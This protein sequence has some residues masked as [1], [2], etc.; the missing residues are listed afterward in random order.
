M[1]YLRKRCDPTSTLR[2][3]PFHK[4]RPQQ[5]QQQLQPSRTGAH[6]AHTAVAHA[7]KDRENYIMLRNFKP[8]Y[9]AK[10]MLANPMQ[11]ATKMSSNPVKTCVVERQA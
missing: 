3:A 10:H 1:D 6:R 11:G 7:S 5:Q 8:A 2:W 4:N 9:V